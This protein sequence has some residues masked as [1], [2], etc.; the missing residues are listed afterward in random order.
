MSVLSS[1]AAMEVLG[2][3]VDK[4][5][6]WLDRSP[7]SSCKGELVG[8]ILPVNDSGGCGNASAMRG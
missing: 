4:S 6:A 5:V 7:V 1:S 3:R 8:A 2:W